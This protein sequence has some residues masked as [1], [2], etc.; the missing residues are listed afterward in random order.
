MKQSNPRILVAIPYHEKKRYALSRVM[1][2]VKELT[3]HNIEVIMRWDIGVYGGKDNVKIQ[4]EMFR[5]MALTRNFDYLYFLGADT[6]PPPD[7][8]ERLLNSNK[9][10]IGG[11]YWGRHEA[12]NSVPDGAVAWIHNKTPQEQREI[13]L[14]DH[15]I[16]VNGM[17]MDAVLFHRS[18]LQNISW[19]SW[20][21]NDDDYPYYDRARELGIKTYIDTGIQCKHYFSE[22]GYTY[23]G[24]IC[25]N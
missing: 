11:V 23:K 9:K 3:Y 19:L 25:Y 24:Q 6:L 16:D 12:E 1:N 20:P 7:V 22:D 4:R 17:G 5:N 13:F 18:V 21:Q 8:L 14:K 10:I 2:A 15:I